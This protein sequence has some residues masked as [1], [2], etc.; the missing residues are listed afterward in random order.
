MTLRAIAKNKATE[1]PPGLAVAKALPMLGH[2]IVGV[3]N[4]KLQRR[5]SAAEPTVGQW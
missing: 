3:N 2:N 5:R 1:K 4:Y